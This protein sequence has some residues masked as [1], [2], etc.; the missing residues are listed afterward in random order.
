MSNY[1]ASFG[2]GVQSTAMLVLAAQDKIPHRTM[3]FCNVGEDSENP[4]TL[5]YVRDYARPFA[6][7]HGIVFHE[8]QTI[9][10][11]GTPDTIRQRE[12]RTKRT[13][14]IP[15]YVGTGA[16]G[17]RSCTYDFK[18]KQ[19]AK[20]TK[21]HG[22]TIDAP[23][24]VALGISID[25]YHRMRSSTVKHQVSD[26]PLIDLR[27][28]RN[29][30]HALITQAGLPTP[31]KSSCYFCPFQRTH[32][33]QHLRKKRPDLFQKAVELERMENDKRRALGKDEMWLSSALKPLDEAIVET[34]QLEMF[35]DEDDGTCDI[36][37][38]CFS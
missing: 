33:W 18:I 5:D 35:S 14:G 8:L 12:E 29:D 30:C 6:E 25:E 15:M 20:W 34:G 21:A 38:Y 1:V 22:A 7:K 11:D 19:V 32:Q 27:M 9:R 16:P 24:H 4:E 26:Y 13:I 3:L 31:P 2:G 23:F 37:G 36:G 17:N 10:R 28:S